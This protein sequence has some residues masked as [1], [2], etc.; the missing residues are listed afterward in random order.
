MRMKL[1][2]VQEDVR[3]EV[4]VEIPKYNVQRKQSEKSF[5]TL[6]TFSQVGDIKEISMWKGSIL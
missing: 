5:M 1:N 6:R 2:S 3:I 4:Q